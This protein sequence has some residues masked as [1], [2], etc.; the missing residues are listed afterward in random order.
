MGEIKLTM[1]LDDYSTLDMGN[2]AYLNCVFD[3]LEEV[4]EAIK[5]ERKTYPSELKDELKYIEDV[6]RLDNFII[7]IIHSDFKKGAIKTRHNNVYIQSLRAS[8]TKALTL[9]VSEYTNVRSRLLS[10]SEAVMYIG[11]PLSKKEIMK[12][13]DLH[14]IHLRN[15]Y[16]NNNY[17]D[18]KRVLRLV[19][20]FTQSLAIRKYQ[21]KH[22][23][24]HSTEYVLRRE[25]R[26]IL[27]D[28]EDVLHGLAYTIS[29]C[30]KNL[31]EPLDE[32]KANQLIE[33]LREKKAVVE[34][35][36]DTYN[37]VNDNIT[38]LKF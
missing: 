36:N 19:K 34:S 13:F 10:I 1:K 29:E 28:T 20:D 17:K 35:L 12:E 23:D 15:M 9:S 32:D 24:T 7:D 14:D 6:W 25:M 11:Y 31:D 5:R 4:K 16:I 8:L 33:L 3:N 37:E 27:H 30:N 18:S 21:I 22:R 26:N 38:K 2:L